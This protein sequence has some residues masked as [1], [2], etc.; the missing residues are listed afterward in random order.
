LKVFVLALEEVE[1]FCFVS[2][3]LKAFIL[4]LKDTKDLFFL[5][6]EVKGFSSCS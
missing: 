5:L 4:A 6:L 1:S 3:S 2:Q